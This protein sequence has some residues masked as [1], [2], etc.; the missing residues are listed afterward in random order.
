MMLLFC[1]FSLRRI[2]IT[3]ALLP[4]LAVAQTKFGG[5]GKLKGTTKT[6]TALPTQFTHIYVFSPPLTGQNNTNLLANVMTQSAIDGVTVVVN[7][8]S[9]ETGSPTSGACVGGNSDT[10]QTDSINYCHTYSWST[11]DGTACSSGPPFNPGTGLGQFFCTLNTWGTKK[12]NPLIFGVTTNPNSATPDYVFG[13]TWITAVGATSQDVINKLKDSCGSYSGYGSTGSPAIV[14]AQMDGSGVVT[15]TMSGSMPFTSGDT[16][17]IKNFDSSPQFN[18]TTQAGTQITSI[19]G[20]T[21]KYQAQCS[22]GCRSA[23]SASTG[24]IVSSQSSWP[25]PTE[26][27]YE[28]AFRAFVAAAI[29]HFSHS[30]S[31]VHPTQVAYM[32]VGYARGAEALPECVSSWPGFVNQT[33]SRQNWLDF[34]ADMSS[35]LMGAGAS[36]TF[37]MQTALNEAGSPTDVSYGTAEAEISVQYTGG[38]GRVFGFGSQGAQQSDVNNCAGASSDWCNQF[39]QFWAGGPSYKN[40]EFELQQID[41]SNPTGGGNSSDGCF[42][43]GFP[44]KTGDL[45]TLLPWLTS[46]HVTIIELYNQDALLAYDPNFCNVSGGTCVNSSPGDWFGSNLSAGTQYSFY[47]TVGQGATCSGGAG[48]GT[49]DCSYATALNA[50]HG[51][52]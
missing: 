51:S 6:S 8:N 32:R 30:V 17:W 33:Q 22:P 18:I 1:M 26:A 15:V 5:T 45:R 49:G 43:G 12:V 48:T 37:H 35:Y 46:N 41:C 10:Q 13:S 4:A 50:A 14:S 2:V 47:T 38:D 23:T 24:N 42:Q 29:Y 31:V 19:T 20:L 39:N 44:G 28:V 36:S 3:C 40:T 34:Y 21:F 52:H 25:I 11:V 7:W 9:V 16:I 27:P